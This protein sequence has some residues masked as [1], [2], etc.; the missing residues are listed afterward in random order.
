M[1]FIHILTGISLFILGFLIKKFKLSYLIA[2]YN[3]SS[4][5]IKK[6]YDTNKLT[7]SIGILLMSSSSIIIIGSILAVVFQEI[8]FIL[9]SITY[10]IFSIHILI[11]L[12]YINISGCALK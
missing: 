9:I 4:Q 11:G 2:G 12:L 1:I 10:I 3:T 8:Q 5:Q 6:L 7:A